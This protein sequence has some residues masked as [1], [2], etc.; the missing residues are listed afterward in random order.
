MPFS[1]GLA[2][3]RTIKTT[4]TLRRTSPGTRFVSCRS[5][6]CWSFKSYAEVHVHEWCLM[7]SRIV[8]L[9][10]RLYKSLDFMTRKLRFTMP[11]PLLAFPLYLVRLR[12]CLSMTPELGEQ[13]FLFHS[14]VVV[15][16]SCS[17]GS[18]VLCSSQGVQGSQDHT[19]TQAVICS[20]LMKRRTS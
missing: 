5:L 7:V 16:N 18:C 3:G 9:P 1:G 2:T 6:L 14:V 20:N 13:T 8:Q 15:L 10:E 19:S 12:T 11:F 4:A 17:A